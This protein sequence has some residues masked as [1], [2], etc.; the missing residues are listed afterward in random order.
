[1]SELANIRSELTHLVSRL[2]KAASPR[3]G[4]RRR[5]LGPVVGKLFGL[6]RRIRVLE[7]RSRRQGP[8]WRRL[9]PKTG[10]I[11]ALSLLLAAVTVRV[12]DPPWVE[13]LRVNTFDLY[14]LL[15]PRPPAEHPVDLDATFHDLS[16]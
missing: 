3:E 14:Q 10:T 12:A 16:S 1:M 5:R 2:T 7:R 9:L 11:L 8:F 4:P 6:L 13:Y 15:S